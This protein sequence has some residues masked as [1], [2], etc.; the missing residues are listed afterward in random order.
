MYSR[1]EGGDAADA[2]GV[3]GVPMARRSYGGSGRGAPSSSDEA[4][5]GTQVD[6]MHPRI[7]PPDPYEFLASEPSG[8]SPMAASTTVFSTGRPTAAGER[9]ADAIVSVRPGVLVVVALL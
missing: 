9:L 8:D 4:G 1:G 3:A 6:A 7:P 5:A 2:G